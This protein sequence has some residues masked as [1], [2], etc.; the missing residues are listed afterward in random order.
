MS[1]ND[2]ER[3]A[4][5]EV[6]LIGRR[7]AATE[8]IT[9]AEQAA[10]TALLDAGEGEAVTAPVEAVMRAKA[11]VSALDAAIH[12]CRS[13]RLEAIRAKR[14]GDAAGLREQIIELRE[15][16]EKLEAKI[17]KHVAA[18]SELQGA[19]FVALPASG[20]NQVSRWQEL[21]NQIASFEI[22]AAALEA[23][24]VPR[25]GVVDVQGVTT[26]DQLLLAA[27]LHESDGPSVESIIA[28]AV[29]CEKHGRVSRMG[30]S[31][32]QRD[33]G[34]NL[35]NFHLVW[36]NGVIVYDESHVQVPAFIRTEPGQ[37]SGNPVAE[38][39]TDIFRCP[40]PASV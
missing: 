35:R 22:R 36:R 9:T 24:E 34:D 32:D 19:P 8:A 28:W 39:G 16:L 12:A 25:G 6:E 14:Q 3:Y 26:P 7:R 11:Q 27:L 20:W 31:M 18:I 13:R 2:V 29:G 23:A 21:Q 30:H 33:F 10:G 15:Q 38:L 1:T 40:A 37:Y 5:K 17:A 4:T